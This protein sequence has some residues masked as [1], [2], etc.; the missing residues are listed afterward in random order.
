MLVLAGGARA[1]DFGALAVNAGELMAMGG[2]QYLSPVPAI[3]L[4]DEARNRGVTD[5]SA[6]YAALY[7]GGTVQNKD[8]FN[9]LRGY[10]VLFV[11]GFLSD[12]TVNPALVDP[13]VKSG[14]TYFTSQVAWL[15][16]LGVDAAIVGIESEASCKANAEKI[17][18][19]VLRSPKR[20]I[21]VAHSKGGL[22]TLEALLSDHGAAA[23]AAGVITL[24]SPFAGSPVAD[25]ILEN[26]F[27]SG[28]LRQALAILGGSDASLRDLSVKARSAYLQ[29]KASAIAGLTMRVP[30]ICFGSRVDSARSMLY[31]T[32]RFLRQLGLANDGVVPEKNTALPGSW[33]VSAA[34]IDHSMTV[35]DDIPGFDRIKFLETLL[36]V[37]DARISFRPGGISAPEDISTS[38]TS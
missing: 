16:A 7:S 26:S 19:S 1:A 11:P 21:I 23:R 12:P 33:S 32:H 3:V 37:L 24:Q 30:F 20:V 36:K 28:L 5:I 29:D 18:H 15:R 25:C 6:E 4:A 38:E 31:A 27:L 13:R 17:A 9:R 10:R 34:R 8:F 22:D 2:E 14:G 35:Y